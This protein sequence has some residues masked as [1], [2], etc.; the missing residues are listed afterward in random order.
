MLT[1]DEPRFANWDQDET[2]ER[3]RYAEQDPAEVGPALVAAAEAVAAQY[4]ALLGEPEATWSRRGLRSNG[5]EFSVDSIARYHL[6]D[7]V[8]HAHDVRAAAG[9]ATRAA[10]DVDAA[11]FAGQWSGLDERHREVL[12]AFVAALGGG[13]AVLEIGSGGGRD[14]LALEERGV[15]VRR[16]D[17]SAGFVSLLREQGHEA[18]R[19]DPLTDELGGPWDG[20][21]A[22][23]SLL[24]VARPDLPTV[25][26]R[27]AAATRPGG[28]LHASLKEGDGDAWSQHGAVQAPRRFTFWRAEPLREVLTAAGWQ[29]DDV[30]AWTGSR[31]Q[32]WLTVRASRPEG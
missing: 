13:G 28:V 4:D 32:P 11:G 8:H 15:R 6:H 25:L 20:V 26:R 5:S 27:L 23:A 21:W 1:E 31:E 24:H 19:L 9:R 12:D 22:A 14:A 10:Y 30:R 2:A 3:E 17:V 18:D 16:T 29:V 7:V